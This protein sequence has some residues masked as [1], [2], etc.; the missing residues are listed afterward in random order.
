MTSVFRRNS[1]EGEM[2]IEAFGVKHDERGKVFGR[3]EWDWLLVYCM[4]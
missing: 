2:W 4:A 1:H 3:E